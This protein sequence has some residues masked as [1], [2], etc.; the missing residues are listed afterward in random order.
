MTKLI[1]TRSTSR[2]TAV[3]LA[4][5]TLMA[6]GS[7]PAQAA[8][9]DQAAARALASV[10]AFPQRTFDGAGDSYEVLDVMFDAD[11]A[12]HVRLARRFHGLRVIGGDLVVHSNRN[13]A[14]MSA[15]H[16]LTREAK[17][18]REARVSAAEAIGTASSRFTRHAA[19]GAPELVVYA[20]GEHAHLAWNVR[21]NGELADGTPSRLNAIVDAQA[22]GLLDAWDDIQTAPAA[23]EAVEPV[24]KIGTGK[25]LFAGDVA[26]ATDRRFAN[27]GKYSMLDKT[28]GG[29]STKDLKH[30]TSGT[31]GISSN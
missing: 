6:L 31:G 11:G 21:L 17:V 8:D 12:E 28:R 14:F 19:S 18:G 22:G 26:L 4:A 1:R 27:F 16:T 30:G 25:T 2:M 24:A 7:A 3:A 23:A 15:T 20:R 9:R 13:G 5:A 29:Q 10:K